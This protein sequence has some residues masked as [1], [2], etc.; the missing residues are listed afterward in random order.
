LN[1]L[2]HIH[3]GSK[4]MPVPAR[5]LAVSLFLALTSPAAHAEG[6][7]EA[8]GQPDDAV[9]T[10]S[11]EVAAVDDEGGYVTIQDDCGEIDVIL[12]QEE[13]TCDPGSRV[14]ATGVVSAGAVMV[15]S[16]KCE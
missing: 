10:V 7:C 14:E 6:I 11:G 9:V 12:P 8:A 15:D 5:I 16:F 13:N 4:T 2:S 1:R 3:S